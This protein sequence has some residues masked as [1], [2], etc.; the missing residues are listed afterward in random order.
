ML[1]TLL[2]TNVHASF[3]EIA[4]HL[5]RVGLGSDGC[6]DGAERRKSARLAYRINDRPVRRD[7]RL[8]QELVGV[9]DAML[10]RVEAG[11]PLKLGLGDGLIEHCGE[12]AC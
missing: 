2:L 3:A 6:D 4:E 9:V 12:S 7:S 11:E 8:S 5:D 1:F 10:K